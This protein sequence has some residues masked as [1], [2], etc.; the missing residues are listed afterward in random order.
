MQLARQ[1]RRH[2]TSQRST[3]ARTIAAIHITWKKLRRDLRD[4]DESREQRLTFIAGVLN[5]KQPLESTRELTDK[6]LGRV[7][8]R[9]RE[10]EGQPELPGIQSIHATTQN[11]AAGEA[12]I[13]HLATA[14]QIAAIEKLLACLGWSDV[15]KDAFIQ[16]RFKRTSPRLL[17]PKEAN[18]LTMILLNIAAANAIRSR[19]S[20]NRVSRALIRVEIPALKRRLG[21][22]QKPSTADRDGD[23]EVYE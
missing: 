5:L 8:D 21:I 19:T 23:D 4:P 12:E 1:E 11:T 6:Q 22:D 3:R 16:R 10:L 13:H 7:L 2:R 17:S 18:S 20:V 9:M 15:A 14:A